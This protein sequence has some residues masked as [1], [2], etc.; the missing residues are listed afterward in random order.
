MIEFLY[1][2]RSGDYLKHFHFPF[3]FAGNA[4]I[5]RKA[6]IPLYCQ[7]KSAP[8]PIPVVSPGEYV[9]EGQIIA[10]AQSADSVHVHASVPGFV[11]N[12]VTIE[13]V[14]QNHLRGIEI[15]TQGKFDYLGKPQAHYPWENTSVYELIRII[16]DAGVVN[17]AENSVSLA[18][19]LRQIKRL[20]GQKL[21]LIA[22][23]FDPSCKLDSF[24][25]EKFTEKV[26]VGTAIIAKILDAQ[27]ITCF[28]SFS[29][30][31]SVLQ[32]LKNYVSF[33]ADYAEKPFLYPYGSF[34]FL[35]ETANSCTID[36]AT[37]VSVFEA[38]VNNQPVTASYVLITG[39][40]LKTP[41]VL[42][43]R[44][45]TPIG[46]LIE[47]CGGFKTKPS[48]IIINGLL[49]GEIIN[50]LDMPVDKSL[51]SIHA[52]GKEINPAAKISRCRHCGGCVRNCPVY[53]DPIRIIT[54]LERNQYTEDVRQALR[55]CRKCGLCSASCASR[56]PLT[57]ILAKA[58]MSFNIQGG[59]R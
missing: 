55:I 37:A 38:V 8:P 56:I 30:N 29:K 52:V 33:S 46:S 34:S 20:G 43:A 35:K 1:A 53:I 9:R 28:H 48:H 41:Q 58:K 7:N 44:I 54:A 15:R 2:K 25:T 59:G 17:T 18:L 27:T 22:S 24:L 13:S 31:G 16:E 45:G 51:K 6:T 23:D 57:E 3:D 26:A 21:S 4:F 39:R 32:T 42:K 36:A 50:N 14:H 11:S 47:E 10:R 19:L 49:K 12:F 40:S 5:P